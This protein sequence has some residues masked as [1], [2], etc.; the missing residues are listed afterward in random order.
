MEFTLEHPQIKDALEDLRSLMVQS[1]VDVRKIELFGST[2]RTS[3]DEAQDIDFFVDYGGG[4]F[5]EAKAAL[6]G[7]V[8]GRRVVVQNLEASYANCPAWPRELPLTIH[9]ILYR[10]GISH[11]SEKLVRTRAH[12]IDVTDLVLG[13]R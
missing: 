7:S 11:F 5:S 10:N 1:V 8:N 13:N 9:I 2:L 3:C 6:E 12:S 4:I